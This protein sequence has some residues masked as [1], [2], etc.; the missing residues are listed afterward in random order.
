[1]PISRS[2]FKNTISLM[3]IDELSGQLNKGENL[4]YKVE[5]YQ[6]LFVTLLNKFKNKS[7]IVVDHN[8]RSVFDF[9][10]RNSFDWC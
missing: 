3:L 10:N 9:D 1:M 2:S 7:L 4:T 5:N 6:E 8:I